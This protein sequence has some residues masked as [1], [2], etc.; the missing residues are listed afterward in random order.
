MVL[1]AAALK[2]SITGLVVFAS[3]VESSPENEICLHT[4]IF[5]SENLDCATRDIMSRGWFATRQADS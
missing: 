4:N 5:T 1:S 2:A 3:C